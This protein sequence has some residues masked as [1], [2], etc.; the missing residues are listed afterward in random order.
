MNDQLGEKDVCYADETVLRR[1]LKSHLR[2][3]I[4]RELHNGLCDTL[5]DTLFESFQ[6][7]LHL[8]LFMKWGL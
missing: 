5:E 1:N 3:L 8:N 6:Q 2:P 4:C 7:S